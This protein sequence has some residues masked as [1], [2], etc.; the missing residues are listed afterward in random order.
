M[1]V[2]IDGTATTVTDVA[3]LDAILGDEP[4]GR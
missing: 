3:E 4:P 2:W 1:Q